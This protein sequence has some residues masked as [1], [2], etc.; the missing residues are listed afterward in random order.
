MF[1]PGACNRCHAPLDLRGHPHFVRGAEAAEAIR[2]APGPVLLV[3][4][5]AWD[6]VPAVDRRATEDLAQVL[7]GEVTLLVVDVVG[8]PGA[9]SVWTQ[10]GRPR[11][12]LLSA[13]NEI[14]RGH[15]YPTERP[16]RSVLQRAHL[17]T[18]GQ[19]APAA[20]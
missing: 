4:S 2:D 20:A 11:S 1:H 9:R 5:R 3:F 19:Q 18:A 12:V 13:G 7:S 16:V 6:E 17:Q 15:D 8:D 10:Q 14:G